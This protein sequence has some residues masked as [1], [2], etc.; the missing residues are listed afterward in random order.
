MH[1]K[2]HKV[3]GWQQAK[4]LNNSQSVPYQKK[5]PNKNGY[6]GMAVE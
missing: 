6:V 3:G 2:N 1:A 4:M 5:V